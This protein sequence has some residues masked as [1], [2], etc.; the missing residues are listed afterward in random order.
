MKI[1]KTFVI[2]QE[3][4]FFAAFPGVANLGGG[5]LAVAF[6]RAPNYQDLPGAP[7]GFS[8]HGD[9]MSQ[10]MVAYSNDNGETWGK[11][12]LL[13]SSP[14]G[15]SQD[16]S[17]FFDGNYLFAN[18]FIWRY[19]PDLPGSYMA[20]DPQKYEFI[21]RYFAYFVP[22]GT[23][24][25][26]SDDR[27]GTWSEPVFPEPLPG[28][29]EVLPGQPRRLHNRGN[30]LRTRDGRLLLAG[31]S[32]RFNPAFQSTATLY[33]SRDNGAS[34]QFLC[35]AVESRGVGVFEEPC[36]YITPANK[37]VIFCRCHK[38]TDGTASERAMCVYAVSTDEGKNWSEP[39]QAGFHAEP[40]AACRMEDDRVLL[41]YGYRKA[42]GQGV[43]FRVCD[44]EL[45]DIGSA[46]EH[47]ICCDNGNVD[48]GYPNIAP[49]GGGR[50]LIVYYMNKRGYRG[51]GLIQGTVLDFNG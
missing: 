10:Y 4:G 30:M 46:A 1:E 43:R 17:L 13:Y 44:P 41:A 50:Y 28:G 21:H 49:L 12:S 11:P 37:W 32:L 8:N 23:Y 14:I 26:R 42:D 15:G 39:V 31:Q 18:S 47:I 5:K 36:L 35:D 48:C 34:F 24:V 33:E 40:V 38:L 6:R 19:L 2:Y 22:Y 3:E 25:M 9:A 45:T 20:S 27:G 7:E 29:L 51:N 16:G